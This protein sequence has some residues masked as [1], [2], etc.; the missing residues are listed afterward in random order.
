M[1]IN[2][3]IANR[4]AIAIG[5]SVIIRSSIFFVLFVFFWLGLTQGNRKEFWAIK[6]RVDRLELIR[7]IR[8]ESCENIFGLLAGSIAKRKI[9]SLG[10]CFEVFSCHDCVFCVFCIL[11]SDFGKVKAVQVD[12]WN[13]L[14]EIFKRSIPPEHLSESAISFLLSF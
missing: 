8:G 11:A 14:A 13:G 7:E 12:I 5:E 4:G 3:P 1:N 6:T 2:S 10:Y 9:E